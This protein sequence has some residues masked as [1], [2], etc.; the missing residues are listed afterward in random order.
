VIFKWDHL[1]IDIKMRE[2]EGERIEREKTKRENRE[3]IVRERIRQR[4]RKYIEFGI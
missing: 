3:R 1:D 2:R 4:E